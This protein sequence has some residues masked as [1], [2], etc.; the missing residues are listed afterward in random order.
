MQ[1]HE[2]RELFERLLEAMDPALEQ[3]FRH[4][5]YL[6]EFPQSG[7]RLDRDGLRRLQ[8]TFPGGTAPR[9]QLR[10]VTGGGDVWFGES[11]IEYADGTVAYGVSRI[12]L[13]DGKLWRE[14]RY[15]GEPFEVPAWRASW[16]RPV[17]EEPVAA[18]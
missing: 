6:V 3:Q 8:E 5:D 9:I 13:R 14:T 18:R 2:V 16:S 10:R 11:L 4:E 7:E 17:M 15:Y 1:E 12:E